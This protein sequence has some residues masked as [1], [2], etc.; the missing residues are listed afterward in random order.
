MK[1]IISLISLVVLGAC[2]T[3]TDA[4]SGL[5]KLKTEPKDCKYLYTMDTSATSYKESGA[6]EYLEKSMEVVKD[7]CEA[8]PSQGQM[9]PEVIAAIRKKEKYKEEL[10][11]ATEIANTKV[12][13]LLTKNLPL[14]NLT[15]AIVSL[16]AV[17]MGVFGKLNEAQKNEFVEKFSELKGICESIEEELHVSES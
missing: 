10:R 1:K 17:D 8:L 4:G 5:N 16:K 6:Y 9:T 11:Q 12:R 2:A 3:T 13:A 7:V 14:Q 15:K